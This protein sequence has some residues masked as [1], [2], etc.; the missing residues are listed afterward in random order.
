V[1]VSV[2]NAHEGQN[3][4]YYSG[5]SAVEDK[6]R[7]LAGSHAI[8]RPTLVV[9]PADVLTSNIAWLLRHFPLFPVPG[10]RARL[11][12]IT[13]QD[14]ARIIADLIERNDNIEVDAAGPDVMTF[15]EY[16]SLIATAC[17]LRRLI[18]PAPAWI[19]FA[20]LYIMKLLLGDIVLTREELLGLK[21]ELLIS[22]QPPLGAQSVKTWL[23]EHG[24]QLGRHYV[25]DLN[26][27]FGV[28]AEDPVL[29]AT[30]AGLEEWKR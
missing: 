12:P 22:H 27:H 18:F 25:N 17:R 14:T 8:V 16:V 2:S 24:E 5:K 9:G 21:Q 4:G 30:A 3:L 10:G 23:I 29:T 26:R 15:M 7:G 13:L 11:Q 28:G 20:G 19:A 1:H 6:V